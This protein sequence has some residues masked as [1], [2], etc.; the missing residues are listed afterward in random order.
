M[1]T[2][3][4]VAALLL[5]ALDAKKLEDKDEDKVSVLP[6]LCGSCARSH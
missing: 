2:K 4:V 5:I 3:D 1:A 6:S